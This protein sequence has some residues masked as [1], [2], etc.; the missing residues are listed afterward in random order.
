MHAIAREQLAQ[1][2]ARLPD[3]IVAGRVPGAVVDLLE[4]VEVYVD[5][6]SGTQI[7]PG[8]IEEALAGLQE[9]APVVDA[10]EL[11][12]QRQRAH[13]VDEVREALQRQSPLRGEALELQQVG[14]EPRDAQRIALHGCRTQIGRE[15]RDPLA[16]YVFVTQAHRVRRGL[17]HDRPPDIFIHE[18]SIPALGGAPR[19]R[20][21]ELD[22]AKR[23]AWGSGIPRSAFLARQAAI[24]ALPQAIAGLAATLWRAVAW[25]Q[26]CV[27]RK[28]PMGRLGAR[29][30]LRSVFRRCWICSA[31]NKL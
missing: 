29:L 9:A 14:E 15:L 13:R 26:G 5:E 31:R 8:D 20:R 17:V 25:S 21:H 2:I 18:P 22:L 10:G 7:A 30:I 3:Q 27:I 4:V 23:R 19:Q 1:E 24:V 11:V 16:Q 6:I 28:F 12:R